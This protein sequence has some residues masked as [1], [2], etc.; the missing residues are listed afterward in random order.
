MADNLLKL[1][2]CLD[3]KGCFQNLP[4]YVACCLDHVSL[5]KMGDETV[6]FNKEDQ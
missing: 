2:A 3:E 1:C 5:V 6:F 4:T